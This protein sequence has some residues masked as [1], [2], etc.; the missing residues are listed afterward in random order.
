MPKEN[1]DIFT[2]LNS[3]QSPDPTKVDVRYSVHNSPYWKSEKLDGILSGNKEAVS[4][5]KSKFLTPL[6][7]FFT[8][9]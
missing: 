2:V 5:K 3:L 7:L 9:N 8:K 4:E 6:F 1:V